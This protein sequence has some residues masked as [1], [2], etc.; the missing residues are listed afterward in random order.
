MM[1]EF[2]SAYRELLLALLEHGEYLPSRSGGMLELIGESLNVANCQ[3]MHIPEWRNFNF[4]FADS[5]AEAIWRGDTNGARLSGLSDRSRKFLQ[6]PAEYSADVC[7][8]YGPKFRES[9]PFVRHCIANEHNT[10]RAITH[11]NVPTDRQIVT[12][13]EAL[14][15]LEFPCTISWQWLPRN[16]LLNLHVNMRSQCAYL[17]MPLDF[18]CQQYLLTKLA[19]ELGLL[20][21]SVSHSYGSLHLYERHINAL[22]NCDDGLL[23]RKAN[24]KINHIAARTARASD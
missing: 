17:I 23:S 2:E 20:V 19:D 22:A 24:E 15:H 10:R 14:A 9:L 6:V 16:G 21:G 3:T 5:L 18:Y 7:A 11:I 8:M 4:E 13:G 1:N 12:E